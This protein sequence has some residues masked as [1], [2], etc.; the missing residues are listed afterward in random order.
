VP[1]D[2]ILVGMKGLF[3]S[4]SMKFEL[5]LRK[6]DIPED[7]LLADLKK[8]ASIIKKDTVTAKIYTRIRINRRFVRHVVVIVYVSDRRLMRKPAVL[9]FRPLKRI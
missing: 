8:V 5:N 7:E 2:E 9:N 6:R 1:L 3:G 4:Q